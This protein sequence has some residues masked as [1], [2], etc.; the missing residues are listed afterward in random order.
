MSIVSDL[1]RLPNNYDNCV[2]LLKNNHVKVYGRSYMSDRIRNVTAQRMEKL[3]AKQATPELCVIGSSGHTQMSMSRI[4]QQFD[5]RAIEDVRTYLPAA[6]DELKRRRAAFGV[7]PPLC[8]I[9]YGSV[10]RAWAGS[11][12]IQSGYQRKAVGL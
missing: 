7:V 1:N 12:P 10:C 11:A 6:L 2:G 4:R 8:A 3:A 9:L 5:R